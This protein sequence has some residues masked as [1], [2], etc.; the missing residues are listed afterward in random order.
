M[1]DSP[2]AEWSL[3]EGG[4]RTLLRAAAPELAD[5]P[6]TLFADGWDNSMW[7]LGS[8]LVVRLPRR[9]LAVPL[10]A[11]E[12]RALPEIGPALAVLGI[13][14][15]IPVIAGE[16]GD[17]FPWPWSVTPWIE[18]TNALRA[19]RAENAAWAPRLA[20]A[21]QA[22]HAPAPVDAPLNPVRGRALITR[23]DVMRPRLDTLPARSALRGAWVD[24]LAA[25]P[26]VEQV[27]I[28]GDLHPGNLLVHEGRL[29]ALID[30]GDVTVGDPAYD[31][32]S[33]WMLFDAPGL[34]A[35]RDA[36][37]SRYDDAT[38]VRARAWAA[39]IAL[40]LLTQSDDR[41]EYLAVGQS[42]AE[43][44]DTY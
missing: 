21:L 3:D 30:F 17:V 18:G 16:P 42:T 11:N 19:P 13:R 26:C 15:P 28:H 34:G 38:W 7:R 20:A 39:Y 5:L 37:D 35:F 33:A 6:L 1:A 24:G 12:Q 4:V 27:W 9:A 25:R 29:A 40:I 44:L 8:E 36:T 22:L 32:A 14:T 2:S 10:I 41:P 43:A 31:L 23:D